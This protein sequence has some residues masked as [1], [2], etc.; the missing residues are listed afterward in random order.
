MRE[1][2]STILHW[3]Q[4]GKWTRT[5]CR[6]TSMN[7]LPSFPFNYSNPICQNW[8]CTYVYDKRMIYTHIHNLSFSP[9]GKIP[10]MAPGQILQTLQSYKVFPW[11]VSWGKA[12]GTTADLVHCVQR[13]CS[14]RLDPCP[15]QAATLLLTHSCISAQLPP[16]TGLLIG[17]PW[18]RPLLMIS[19]RPSLGGGGA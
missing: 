19:S 11:Q 2:R 4:R 12:A 3:A 6:K 7:T 10:W 5:I 13:S 18:P 14:P 15:T 8:V 17:G 16:F 9:I 1:P